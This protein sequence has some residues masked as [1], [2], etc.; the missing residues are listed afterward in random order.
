MRGHPG[1]ATEASGRRQIPA[2]SVFKPPWQREARGRVPTWRGAA[3]LVSPA[4]R[5]WPD[6]GRSPRA[7]LSA[8]RQDEER[9]SLR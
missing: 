5:S 6:P 3:G 2:S 9:S 4:M 7:A 1:G 8:D